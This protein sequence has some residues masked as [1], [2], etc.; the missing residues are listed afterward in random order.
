MT[1]KYQRCDKNIDGDDTKLCTCGVTLVARDSFSNSRYA[2]ID[3]CA[4]NPDLHSQFKYYEKKYESALKDGIFPLLDCNGTILDENDSDGW[5][6]LNK[7]FNYFK[8]GKLEGSQ[9]YLV[10]LY[11]HLIMLSPLLYS[12]YNSAANESIDRIILFYAKIAN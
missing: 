7:S 2:F 10:S 5:D 6:N 1:T 4:A 12:K 11:T 8:C 9:S 3:F